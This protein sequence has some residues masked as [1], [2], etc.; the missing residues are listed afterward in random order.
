MNGLKAIAFTLLFLAGVLGA[1]FAAPVIGI[2][3]IGLFIFYAVK[4]DLDNP[5]DQDDQS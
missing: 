3:L 5:D 1:I 4:Y 2:V